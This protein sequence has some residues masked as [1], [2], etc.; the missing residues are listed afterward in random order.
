MKSKPDPASTLSQLHRAH[1]GFDSAGRRG[2]GVEDR[3]KAQQALQEAVA[4]AQRVVGL[5]D[6]QVLSPEER[7]LRDELFVQTTLAAGTLSEVR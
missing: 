2:M 4:E 7:R 3:R 1:R 5:L 6:A